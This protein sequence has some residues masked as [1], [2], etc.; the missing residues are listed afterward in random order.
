MTGRKG[1]NAGPKPDRWKSGPDP[2]MHERYKKWQQNR[3]QAK[4]RKEEWNLSFHE[5]LSIWG[6]DIEKRGRTWD[7]MTMMRND[8]TKPWSKDNVIIVTRQ[9][10]GLLQAQKTLETRLARKAA[11]YGN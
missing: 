7:S 5:W 8:W 9:E 1:Q 11:K 4:Y 3:N 10:H 2:Q 6:D